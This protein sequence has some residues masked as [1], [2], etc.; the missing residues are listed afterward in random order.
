MLIFKNLNN[1]KHG[2]FIIDSEENI[3]INLILLRPLKFILTF[4]TK[5]H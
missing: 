3:K 4:K 1:D 2:K 5:I